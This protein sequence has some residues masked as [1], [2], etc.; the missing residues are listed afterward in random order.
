LEKGHSLDLGIMQINSKNLASLGMSVFDAF[1]PCR[2]VSAAQKILQ[3]AMATGSSETE[4]QAA[5]LITLSRYNTGQPLAGIA[6]GYV[7]EV[8]KAQH[9]APAKAVQQSPALNPPTQWDIWGATGTRTPGWFVAVNE[10]IDFLR[11]GA[12]STAARLPGRAAGQPS[13]TGVPYELSAFKESQ[14][15]QR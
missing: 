9:I 7:D 11:A 6:N 13:M 14:T 8:I 1:D 2:S 12:Q 15:S 5:L 3:F 4:R 10:S